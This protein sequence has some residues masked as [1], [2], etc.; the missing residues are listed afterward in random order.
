MKILLKYLL[1]C[2]SVVD[3]ENYIGKELPVLPPSLSC[4]QN[5]VNEGGSSDRMVEVDVLATVRLEFG[6]K[7]L[8]MSINL[9]DESGH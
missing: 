1:C 7:G 9:I 5:Q 2:C 8:E 4:Y 3:D 6:V